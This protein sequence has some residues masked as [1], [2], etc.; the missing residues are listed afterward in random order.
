MLLSLHDFYFLSLKLPVVPIA[1]AVL[2]LVTIFVGYPHGTRPASSVSLLVTVSMAVA[3]LIDVLV[4]SSSSDSLAL[5]APLGYLLGIGAL[6]ISVSRPPSLVTPDL[7]RVVSTILAVHLVAWLLQVIVYY[8]FGTYLDVSGWIS[9]NP[10][11][12]DT[13]FYGWGYRG[14]L[15]RFTGL[16]AEPAIYSHSIF[17]MVSWR[18]TGTRWRPHLLDGLAVAT[19]VC[20]WSL[21]GLLLSAGLGAFVLASRIPAKYKAVAL[22]MFSALAG[23]ALFLNRTA[24][25]IERSS[26]GSRD[27]STY[28]RFVAGWEYLTRQHGLSLLVGR[29]LG[30]YEGDVM[31][32]GR[33][34]SGIFDSLV[35]TG[36]LGTVAFLVAFLV[37]FYI[38]KA[39]LQPVLLWAGS[40]LSS[41]LQTNM[42][43]WTWAAGMMCASAWLF[44]RGVATPDG[45]SAGQ[46]NA[47]GPTTAFG[48]PA[49]Y[50]R[51]RMGSQ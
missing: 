40:F 22:T 17:M 20:T 46:S 32:I 51:P 43:W 6:W 23:L 1:G 30:T 18:L 2:Y 14:G 28:G 13:F 5:K 25:V 21:T 8:S 29:G 10:S 39:S 12:H 38:H 19:M 47:L 3:V 11:R 15:Q 9:D 44:D 26:Q 34:G 27:G 50:I 49:S 45:D 31:H 42:M 35:Y 16:Y 7:H 48:L 37:L 41:P 36:V 4:V 33:T 24:Y